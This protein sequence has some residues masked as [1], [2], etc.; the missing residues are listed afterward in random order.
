MR[1]RLLAAPLDKEE[2]RMPFP[3]TPV[4]RGEGLYKK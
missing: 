3:R 2:P 1:W 4:N